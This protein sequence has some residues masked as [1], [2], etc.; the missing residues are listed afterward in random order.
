LVDIIVHDP[1][2]VDIIPGG[3]G[4]E[5]LV[6][7]SD[8]KWEVLIREFSHLD[9]YDCLLFDT[10]AGI[11]RHVVSLCMTVRDIV[12]VIVPQPTSLTDAYSLL[13]VLSLNGYRHRVNV[14]VNQAKSKK[15]AET[16]FRK[17]AASVH[18]YLLLDL[19]YLGCLPED[20]LVSRAVAMQRPFI[21]AYPNGKASRSVAKLTQK[22]LEQTATEPSE[23]TT[24]AFW[25]ALAGVSRQPLR[26]PQR[27]PRGRMP[28]GAA[29][30]PVREMVDERSVAPVGAPAAECS[31]ADP[32]GEYLRAMLSVTQ[33]MADQLRGIHQALAKPTRGAA[34]STAGMDDPSKSLLP[35]IIPLD[36][37]AYVKGSQ[38]GSDRL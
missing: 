24:R 35:P 1:S 9:G 23:E 12:L 38:P 37:E 18:Q 22:L 10:S 13:K 11:S 15:L 21:T 26:L 32:N 17:F 27:R 2:G 8:E 34:P 7:L 25:Q 29:K 20:D 31:S 6:D 28:G 36:F 4:V 33:E 3:S 30:Q 16:V 19:A 14:I 5:G